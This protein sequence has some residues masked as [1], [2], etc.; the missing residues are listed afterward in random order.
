MMSKIVSFLKI[1][2]AILL[3]LLAFRI[4]TVVLVPLFAAWSLFTALLSGLLGVAALGAVAF[5]AIKL[6]GGKSKKRR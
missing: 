5:V 2:G 6:F 4:G 1:S 3:I